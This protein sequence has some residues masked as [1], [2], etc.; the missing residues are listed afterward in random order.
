MLTKQNK[1]NQKTYTKRP[2]TPQNTPAYT[3][4]S[5]LPHPS[6]SHTPPKARIPPADTGTDA[7]IPIH[8][9][10]LADTVY[11]PVQTS[12]LPFRADGIGVLREKEEE[13]SSSPRRGSIRLFRLNEQR[14]R[15]SDLVCCIWKV[16]RGR[17][18]IE[19]M[20]GDLSWKWRLIVFN[21]TVCGRGVHR[22]SK[23]EAEM[24]VPKN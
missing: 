14:E 3:S 17:W 23:I 2:Q 20:I 19:G 24:N 6:H 4:P 9:V 5:Q 16:G 13:R 11:H 12:Q 8:L 1:K 18:T 10:H 21:F 15:V 22:T 7:Y